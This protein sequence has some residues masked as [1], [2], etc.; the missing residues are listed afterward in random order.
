M[1]LNESKEP[2][3]EITIHGYSK[4]EVGNCQKYMKM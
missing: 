4:K 2:C 1:V 3:A